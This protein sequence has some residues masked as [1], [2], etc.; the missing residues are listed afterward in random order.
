MTTVLCFDAESSMAATRVGQ[1]E[2]REDTGKLG[3]EEE[4][5]EKGDDLFMTFAL[6]IR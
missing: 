2:E 3:R 5:K 1:C 6:A 4:E